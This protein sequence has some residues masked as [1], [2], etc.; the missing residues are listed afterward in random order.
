MP[1]EEYCYGWNKHNNLNLV[2]LNILAKSH[3]VKALLDET[4]MPEFLGEKK[5]DDGAIDVIHGQETEMF[6]PSTM[7]PYCGEHVNLRCKILVCSLKKELVHDILANHRVFG[8]TDT[9]HTEREL[10]DGYAIEI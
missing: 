5:D 4:R 3:W 8:K 6:V 9:R 7:S 2:F 10:G 1:G